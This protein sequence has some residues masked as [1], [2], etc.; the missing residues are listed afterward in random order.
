MTVTWSDLVE[1]PPEA[2]G[3][4][5][6]VTDESTVDVVGFDRHVI[7]EPD[8]SGIALV[9]DT[10]T[11]HFAGGIDG[12]GRAEHL[13]H[14]HPDGSNTFVGIERITAT[15]GGRHG[16]VSLTCHGTTSSDGVVHGVWHVV[17]GSGADGLTGLRGRGEFTAR[18]LPGRQWQA[19]DTF[20]HWYE[21]G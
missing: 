16:S 4:P 17:P 20:T 8:A 14:L 19:R 5:G 21:K 1:E 10:L 7:A 12:E 9:R 3:P 18:Q 15:I 13:R 6:A 11:E 2:I